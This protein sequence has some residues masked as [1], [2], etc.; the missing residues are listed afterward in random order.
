M[1]RRA[2][3]RATPGQHGPFSVVLDSERAA[4]LV[5]IGQIVG[6]TMTLRELGAGARDWFSSAYD[7]VSSKSLLDWPISVLLAVAVPIALLILFEIEFRRYRRRALETYNEMMR[8]SDRLHATR[9]VPVD[10]AERLEWANRTGRYAPGAEK[11][12]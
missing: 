6:H 2:E 11:A 4:C 8:Q 1:P 7:A 12:K 10:P 5:Y 9:V 3:R